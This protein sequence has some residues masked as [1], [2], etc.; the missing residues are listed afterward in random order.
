MFVAGRKGLNVLQNTLIISDLQ[1]H[2]SHALIMIIM[3]LRL[4]AVSALLCYKLLVFSVT[5]SGPL[6]RKASFWFS[7]DRGYV[8]SLKGFRPKQPLVFATQVTHV[9]LPQ[10]DMFIPTMA[11]HWESAFSV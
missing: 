5:G 3:S 4:K 10:M 8:T 9:P 7:L 2:P 11:N 6:D 1:G